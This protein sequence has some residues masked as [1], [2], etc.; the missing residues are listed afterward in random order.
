MS[1]STEGP[2]LV[3]PDLK[4]PDILSSSGNLTIVCSPYPEALMA[5]ALLCRAALR[6]K[7]LFQ[8]TYVEPVISSDMFISLLEKFRKSVPLFVGIEVVGTVKEHPK[9]ATPIMI[10]PKQKELKADYV[11]FSSSLGVSAYGLVGQ[12]NRLGPDEFLRNKQVLS[13]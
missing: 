9:G 4:Y 10:G 2:S 6:A 1:D 11:D 7:Q 13:H 5:S 3:L 8:V 12:K